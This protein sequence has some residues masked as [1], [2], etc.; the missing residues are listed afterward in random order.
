MVSFVFR[1]ST[2]FKAKPPSLFYEK[3]KRSTY[4]LPMKFNKKMMFLYACMCKRGCRDVKMFVVMKL[5][6]KFMG[7]VSIPFINFYATK[8]ILELC[9]KQVMPSR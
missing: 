7:V 3:K 2:Y 9:Y 4:H 6:C 8:L 1:D 5:Y